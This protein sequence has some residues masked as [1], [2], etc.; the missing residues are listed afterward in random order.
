MALTRKLLKS[1]GLEE[2]VIDSIIEA[3]TE[4][5]DALK[6][7]R[8]DALAE[9]NKAADLTRQLNEAND[10]LAKAGDAARIQK[11]LDDY[12]AEVAA[13]KTAADKRTAMREL[14]KN[15]VGIQRESALDLILAAEK[16]DGYEL[17]ENGQFR[18][19]AGIE[20]AMKQKHADWIGQIDTKGVPTITPPA[21]GS[22]GKM[23]REEIYRKD[24]RGRYVLSTAERQKALVESMTE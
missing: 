23:T 11:E 7:Q 18:D 14:L 9:A 21:G 5:T 1:F 6:K 20:S 16:L 12:K 13:E 17:D 24:D 4:S 10:K 8:D 15:K 19:A 3:H 2:S 22:A